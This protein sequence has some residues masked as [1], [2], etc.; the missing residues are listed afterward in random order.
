MLGPGLWE[1][2][3]SPPF[4]HQMAFSTPTHTPGLVHSLPLKDELR[5]PLSL[6]FCYPPITPSPAKKHKQ[7]T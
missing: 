6:A 3:S 2:A 4:A 1:V 5:E 7:K